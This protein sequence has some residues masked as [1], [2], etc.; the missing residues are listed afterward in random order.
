MDEKRELQSIVRIGSGARDHRAP[1]VL[2]GLEV[3]LQRA[4]FEAAGLQRLDRVRCRFRAGH[5][6]V[7]GH[8][9]HQCRAAQR[10]RVRNRLVAIGRVD[11]ELDLT[12]A[13]RVLDVRPLE[14]PGRRV[15]KGEMDLW[16]TD[17]AAATPVEILVARSAARV[18]LELVGA[19]AVATPP[20]AP[21]ASP[22]GVPR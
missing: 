12:V 3:A 17:D 22:E 2:S 11:D 1:L 20:P 18:R 19:S 21:A 4:H 15:W 5:G 6:G 7:V 9:L 10:L 13:D 8:L 16:L 14:L